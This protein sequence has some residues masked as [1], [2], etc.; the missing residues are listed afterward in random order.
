[1]PGASRRASLADDPKRDVL[2][3]HPI[4]ERAADRDTHVLG[5]GLNQGL[6]GENMLDLGGA[7]AMRERAEG[8]M[9]RGM[10]VAAD[11]RRA[12][13]GK[14]LFGADD[15]DDA[16]AKIP[17]IKIFDAELPGIRGELFDLNAAF[18]IVDSLRAIGCRYIVIDDREGFLRRPDWPSAQ[19][20]LLKSLGACY[21]MHQMTVDINQAHAIG[22]G[23]DQMVVPDLIVKRARLD[24]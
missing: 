4:A 11:D 20:Q 19:P 14:A 7:D 9:R 5:L 17:L 12:G 3:T 22:F 1:M 13:Q 15:M 16:L 10:A 6:G 2:G 8:A 23:V 18:G 21:L 24:H